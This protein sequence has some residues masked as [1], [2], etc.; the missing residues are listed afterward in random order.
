MFELNFRTDN[1]AF[2]IEG[3]REVA[4]ALS[5]VAALVDAGAISGRVRDINGNTIGEWSYTS[6]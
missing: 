3:P 5:A 1:E 2:D 4:R 6:S